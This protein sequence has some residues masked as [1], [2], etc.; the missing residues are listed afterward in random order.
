MVRVFELPPQGDSFKGEL[1]TSVI[2]MIGC[3]M[4][5]NKTVSFIQPSSIASFAHTYVVAINPIVRIALPAGA[6]LV[7]SRAA[8][9]LNYSSGRKSRAA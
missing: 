1:P 3:Q 8:C 2:E 4:N 5:R 9:F 7:L 6:S